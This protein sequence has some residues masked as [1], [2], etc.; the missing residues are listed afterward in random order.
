MV[1]VMTEKKRCRRT[2]QRSGSKRSPSVVDPVISA[3]RTVTSLRSSMARS[4]SAAPQDGQKRAP[5]GTEAEQCGHAASTAT[6]EAY[7]GYGGHRRPG[8]MPR[9]ADV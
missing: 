8:L 3:K 4:A 1:E 2:R 7:T 9:H 5:S 6:T